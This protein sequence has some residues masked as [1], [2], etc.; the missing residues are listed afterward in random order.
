MNQSNIL[1][2]AGIF[3]S[4]ALIVTGAA[5][6]QTFPTK[7]IRSV[8]PYSAGSGPDAVMRFVG[9]KVSRAWSQQL[10][11][12]NRPGANGFIAIGE[13]KKA[14]ADGY[15]VLQVDNTHMALQ[16]HLFKQLPYDPVKDFDPVAPLY[17][18]NFFIVVPIDSPWNNVADLIKAAKAKPGGITYGSWGIGSVAHVGAA[19]FEAATGTQ[20]THVPFK[21]MGAV[22]TSIAGRDVD[23]AFGTAATAGPMYKAKKVKFIALAAP[24]RL[25]G[26]SEVPTVGEAGGPANFEVKAWVGLF[27]PRGTPKAA[28]DRIHADVSKALNEPDVKEKMGGFGFEPWFGPSAELTMAIESDSRKFGE[29]VKRAKISLD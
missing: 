20:M 13:A 22:Y 18:T 14:A 16:P 27:A 23:W 10:V 25:P 8:A 21:E 3:V 2:R 17:T 15:T 1:A 7:P 4:T 29:V 12:D 19:M 5:T 9:D 6:A 28:I 24:K 11:V 26:F